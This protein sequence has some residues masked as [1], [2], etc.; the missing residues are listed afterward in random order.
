[1]NGMPRQFWI[2]GPVVLSLIGVSACARMPYETQTVYQGS[3]AAVVLEHEVEPAQYSHPIRLSA[4]ELV[5]ILRGFSIRPQQRLPLRWF[6][7]ERRPERL[8]REE[9]LTLLAPFI[10]D[11]FQKAGVDERVH[12]ALFAQG[13]NRS[14][15]RTVT[16]G[17]MAIR[18]QY[19]YL[20]VEYL[21]TEVP[22]HSVD[23]YF[24]NN[25]NL[26]PVPGSF[27]VFFEPGRYWVTDLKGV[28]ALEFREFLGTAPRSSPQS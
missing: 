1:M 9:E 2:V 16:S 26:P 24:P 27:L 19:L 10:V 13:H 15:A 21:H 18:E 5:S 23:Q 7:E 17:W 25:P 20:T 22:V 14:D 4:D 8:F 28:R 6:A 11:G 12:F 3:R